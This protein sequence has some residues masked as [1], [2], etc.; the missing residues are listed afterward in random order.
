MQ[1]REFMWMSMR[2][3]EDDK[4]L[5]RK[6]RRKKKEGCNAVSFSLQPPSFSN[7]SK[8]PRKIDLTLWS[9]MSLFI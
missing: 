4:E 8:L 1:F 3:T 5:R 7:I 6:G 2:Q 9:T